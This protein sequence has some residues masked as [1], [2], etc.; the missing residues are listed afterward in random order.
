MKRV[1]V[2]GATGFIGRQ[3]LKSLCER[4]Y[5][6][7]GLSSRVVP[8][9]QFEWEDIHWHQADLRNLPGL[10]NLIETIR[11]THLLHFAWNTEPGKYWTT[12]ENLTWVQ[13]SIE[14]LK[15]FTQ[16]G[17]QRVVIAGTCAEYDWRYGFCVEGQTP[18]FPAT[19]YGVS[20]HALQVLAQAYANQCSLSLAW[21][22]IFFV[23][24]PHEHP[25]RLVPSI[26]RGMLRQESVPCSHG[27]Q[28]RDFL[29]VQDVA[30]AFVSLLDSNVMGPVNIASGA[31]V[32]ILEI[33]SKIANSFQ[34]DHLLRIGSLPAVANE[35]PLLVADIHRLREEVK[36]QP[37]FDLN[38]GLTQTIE[39]WRVQEASSL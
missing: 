33:A 6:V 21:G 28:I 3:S 35:P 32:S 12:P 13:S 24:G 4:G 19:L 10:S 30:D 29:H 5:T 25:K 18:L 9:T 38:T 15:C 34:T 36:W 2:T 31:P 14:I 1:L 11:P 22:R 26:V 37:G 16:S 7:H 17:G 20:K 23:Y 27:R 39:W 8:P